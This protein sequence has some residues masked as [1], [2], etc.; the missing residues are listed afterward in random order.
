LALAAE[1]DELDKQLEALT[2]K[3]A[4]QLRSLFGVGP[5]TAAVLLFV[6]GDNP[7]R[8]KNEAAM[9]SLCGVNPLPHLLERR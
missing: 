5:N 4:Q 1:L 8:L 6:P 7:D 3:H 2:P 9:A